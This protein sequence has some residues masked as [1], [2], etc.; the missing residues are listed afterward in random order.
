MS[1][2][3]KQNEILNYVIDADT[4]CVSIKG[5]KY[6]LDYDTLME[7]LMDLADTAS[8]MERSQPTESS[9][10]AYHQ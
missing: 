7:V 2:I 5:E 3:V 8:Q 10:I 1:Q 4:A 6:I 9:S